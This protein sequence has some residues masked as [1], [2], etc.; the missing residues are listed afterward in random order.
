M[1]CRSPGLLF[2]CPRVGKTQLTCSVL[3]GK[4]K[5][6]VQPCTCFPLR[7]HRTLCTMFFT[8]FTAFWSLLEIPLFG[9]SRFLLVHEEQSPGVL[10][11]PAEPCSHTSQDVHEVKSSMGSLC[12]PIHWIRIPILGI[13]CKSEPTGKVQEYTIYAYEAIVSITATIRIKFIATG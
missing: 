10:G 5:N 4:N 7:A 8:R 13:C 11:T 6:P 1:P 2:P 9:L 12:Q 3:L